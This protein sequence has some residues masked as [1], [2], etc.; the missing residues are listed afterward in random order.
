MHF[1]NVKLQSWTARNNEILTQKPKNTSILSLSS[2]TAC[3]SVHFRNH[4]C[5]SPESHRGGR[6]ESVPDLNINANAR[7]VTGS[8]HVYSALQ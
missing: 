6:S 2:W 8:V 5:I 4:K 7:S 3:F 1:V